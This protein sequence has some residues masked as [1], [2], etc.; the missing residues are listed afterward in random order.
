LPRQI[1][2]ENTTR[3]PVTRSHYTFGLEIEGMLSV[4]RQSGTLSEKAEY[5]QNAT[6][7]FGLPKIKYELDQI[8]GASTSV[9]TATAE[10]VT[11]PF[12]V[13]AIG[14]RELLTAVRAAYVSAPTTRITFNPSPDFGGHTSQARI[15]KVSTRGA[16]QTNMAIPAGQLFPADARTAKSLWSKLTTE[17]DVAKILPLVA[18]ANTLVTTLSGD[19]TAPLYAYRAQAARLKL[20]FFQWLSYMSFE[21][22]LP[23]INSS[24]LWKDFHGCTIKCAMDPRSNG[25]P[26]AAA[27]TMCAL[28]TRA[29]NT[30]AAPLDAVYDTAISAIASSVGTT[31]TKVRNAWPED[32]I[33]EL[34]RA[35]AP[36]TERPLRS[37]VV[38]TKLA[39]IIE[40]RHTNAPINTAAAAATY[41]TIRSVTQLQ[42]QANTL[43]TTLRA[44]L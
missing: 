30:I 24:G 29:T 23:L 40:L 4:S 17:E 22:G 42:E 27:T 25:I 39:P 7:S 26:Y 32:A 16:C 19:A 41:E 12:A 44:L 18:A 9:S 14:A 13:T 28:Y 5:V 20:W 21:V 11:A 43:N 38:G 6:L 36:A 37:S 34:T 31:E 33:H 3:L 1:I 8:F 35:D 15:T 2:A 10:I